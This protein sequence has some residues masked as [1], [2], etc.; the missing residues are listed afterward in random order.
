MSNP[1]FF[2]PNANLAAQ[3][4]TQI[5]FSRRFVLGLNHVARRLLVG[6]VRDTHP[7]DEIVDSA[8]A[9]QYSNMRLY[10]RE[11]EYLLDALN[12]INGVSDELASV[13]VDIYE[14]ID[15][16]IDE[17]VEIL[18]EVSYKKSNRKHKVGKR[19]AK[20]MLKQLMQQY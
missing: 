18:A 10:S 15:N 1:K 4:W 9:N 11:M 12:D 16:L 6:Q 8:W 17:E 20:K 7:E 13:L 3:R 14:S 2:G 5:N 19:L